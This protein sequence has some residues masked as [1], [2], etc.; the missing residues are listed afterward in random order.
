M[1]KYLM[2][3]NE[4]AFKPSLCTYW[5]NWTKRTSWGWWDEWGDTA[6]RTL[7]SKVKPWRYKAEHATSRSQRPPTILNLYEW[8]GNKHLGGQ[9]ELGS[10][11]R[12]STSQAGSFS[13]YTGAPR[14]KKYVLYRCRSYVSKWQFLLCVEVNFG[15]CLLEKAAVNFV[16]LWLRANGYYE[17]TL[18]CSDENCIIKLYYRPLSNARF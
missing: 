2:K 17:Y 9:I 16:C 13:H 4:W 11:S 6:F 3:W 1:K 14:N 12:S 15:N 10:S 8:V 7:E 5:L 18:C